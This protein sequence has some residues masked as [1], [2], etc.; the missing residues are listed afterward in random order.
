MARPAGFPDSSCINA[1]PELVIAGNLLV[2]DI[3]LA[4]GRTLMGEPGGALLHAALAARL[5]GIRVGLLS[6]VGADYPASALTAL[7][8]R[9]V[10]LAGI[11]RL[12]GRGGRAWILYEP[13]TRRVVHHLD[14]PP[15][16]ALSPTLADLPHGWAE[17]RG[18]HLA[19]MPLPRQTELAVAL[20]DVTR[21]P[22]RV[23]LD[24]YAL[25]E[26]PRLEEWSQVL[27]HVDAFFPSRDELR[28]AGDSVAIL[29]SLAGPRLRLLA[30]KAGAEGGRLI[31]TA[32]G[33]EHPWRARALRAVDPTGAGD[34]FVGGFL[35][36]W[37]TDDDLVGALEQGIVSASFAVED[38]GGRGLLAATPADARARRAEWFP[39][40][41]E[42][43]R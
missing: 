43:A 29:Q 13:M 34:A 21:H 20:A 39:A 28:L 2:D 8:D 22:I 4:D 12:A 1:A 6:V 17:A 36:G 38:W 35:A 37:L 25:V 14:A 26:A 32:T 33:R 30:L 18:F 24:P 19:P 27:P 16:E 7:E 40:A 41:V 3:V 31:E 5:W 15:H 42:P 23:S 11:R 10:D 9:G